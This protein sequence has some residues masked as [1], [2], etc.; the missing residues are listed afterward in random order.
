MID[1]NTPW[2]LLV[3]DD[4]KNLHSTKRILENIPINVYTAFSGEE[5]LKAIL[6]NDFFLV[7]MDVQMPDMNGFETASYI[8]GNDNYK[9]IPIIFATAISK[10]DEFV[11][12]GYEEGAVDYLFKPLNPHTLICKVKVFLNLYN[13]RIELERK[14]EELKIYDYMVAHD[15][16][17]P[18]VSIHNYVK[19]IK[20]TSKVALDEKSNRY[21]DKITNNTNRAN[22]LIKDILTFSKANKTGELKKD[23]SIKKCVE[24]ALSNLQVIIDDNSAQVILENLERSVFCV[25][26]KIQQLFQNLISNAIK[27]QKPGSSPVVKIVLEKVDSPEGL[28]IKIID[29]GIGFPQEKANEVFSPFKRLITHDEYEGSGIG[30]AT[31]KRIADFHGWRIKAESEV[32][33]GSMFIVFVPSPV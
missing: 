3:D 30:L 17:A 20:M 7:L 1:S 13:Q 6:S 21:L 22:Q 19:L 8:R 9:N 15:L 27:Y 24:D 4:E 33:K 28:E 5:A 14:N 32:G 2:L 31:C 16:S 11:F 23:I 29:N 25:P 18:L 26:I 10:E 12:T